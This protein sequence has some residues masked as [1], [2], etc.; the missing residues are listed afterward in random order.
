MLSIRAY[1]QDSAG[2]VV[3]QPQDTGE[4]L[5][6]PQMGWKLNYY[7]NIITNYG[8]KLA[9]SDTLDDFPGLSCIYLRLPWAY[10]EPEE[11]Q[12]NWS[13]V[14]APAQRWIDK[15][16]QVAFRFS[17]SES[18]MRY[19]TP[20]WVEDAGATG[21]SFTFGKG[22]DE[23][24]PFWEPDYADPIFL[25]KHGNF[26]AAAAERYDG[27]PN[28]AFIDVGSFGVWGEGHTFA[29]TQLKYPAE[30]VR[31]H[32]DLYAKYFKETLLAANDDFSFQGDETMAY[33][34]EKG[35]TLRDDSILVQPP[36]KSYYHAEMAQAFWPQL[37]VILEHE[38]Y[39]PSVD[40][41]AWH[42]DIFMRAIEEYH[43]AYMCIHWF[44]REFLEKERELI[45]A[46]NL[47]LGYRLQ[48]REASWPA[49]AKRTGR[50]TFA[51]T[52]ANAGV[53][54]CYPGG[55]VAF[56]LKDA[57]G[58]IVAVF[59][60]EG[61]D[62]RDLDIGPPDEAPAQ[63][64][65]S[66]HGMALNMPAGTFDVFVSVGQRDGTPVIALP[67]AEHDGQRRYRLGSIAVLGE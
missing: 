7:S 22:V 48:L 5:V 10:I 9:P 45:D 41:G 37:P 50:I 63:A 14:D 26:L 55:S 34:L 13:I 61:F 25:E 51:S 8:S 56:T 38:H 32:I 12:F 4:A 3:V 24:G 11:G 19:A 23:G 57:R 58:G 2:R 28:V 27:N 39:Q 49:S 65:E 54:P 21:Y 46:V 35:M 52:W 44:P 31:N 47:R 1:A 6:N 33:A 18:W 66:T 59:V 16:L 29:S 53:A 15:G 20:K 64:L 43:A 42:R 30:V 60:N 40:R 17:V 36:P 62:V 67:L